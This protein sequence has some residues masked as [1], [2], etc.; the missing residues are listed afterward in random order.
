MKTGIWPKKIQ[1]AVAATLLLA[2]SG[3][4]SLLPKGADPSTGPVASSEDPVDSTPS[5]PIDNVIT[6][7][8]QRHRIALLLPLTGNNAPIGESIAN[9]TTQ[10][11]L[12]TGAENM[13]ITRYDTA[14]GATIA[15]QNAIRDGNK[16]I[17]GPLLS[18][19]VRAAA[20]VA[21]PANVPI[22]SFSNDSSI[23][24]NMVFL[25]GFV[26]DQSIE[27]VIR[28]ARS[29]GMNRFAGLIPDGVY[30]QR[31]SSSLLRAVRNAGGSVVRLE[32]YGR[33]RNAINSAV[34]RLAEVGDYDALLIGDSGQS[35]IRIVPLVRGSGS[36]ARILGTE[37]WNT[38]KT[39]SG[40]PSLRGAWFASVSDGLYVQYAEKYRAR[41]GKDPF[42]LSTLGYDSVLLAYRVARNW[43][44]G[45]NFPIQELRDDGGF[46]GLDGAFRFDRSGIAERSLEVQEVRQN[47][48][49]IISAAPRSFED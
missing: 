33:S 1:V 9:A 6:S 8:N 13:R 29:Q 5:G 20:N 15:A 4:A 49:A 7:D 32:S 21:T 12:D 42:R 40:A 48:V 34:K 2:L 43:P 46:V 10:A 47:G 37:L 16:L 41:F 24:N 14:K 35:A 28:Y 3:C 44:M 31:A 19:N 17:L 23:A 26:P 11:L 36:N 22:I 25:M 45:T 18:D 39:L 30:G 27:R 38:D